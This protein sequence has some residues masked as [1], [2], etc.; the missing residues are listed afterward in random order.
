MTDDQK[1][2]VYYGY[3]FHHLCQSFY[4]RLDFVTT[5]L[6]LVGG[7]AAATGVVT[8]APWLV[9]L[10]GFTL[11]VCAAIGVVVQPAIKA[12]RHLRSKCQYWSVKAN[13]ER[14]LA[15]AELQVAI[16]QAQADGAPGINTLESPAYNRAL[17]M[18][19]Y[20]NGYCNLTRTES[21]LDCI[22]S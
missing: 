1:Y 10:S 20:K 6:Q 3:A 18:L 8:S 9:T 17:R 12:D 16:T 13:A 2:D 21:I 22:T 5:F 11:A 15:G 14:G 7:S 19:G 4:G